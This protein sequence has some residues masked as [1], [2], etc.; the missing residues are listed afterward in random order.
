MSKQAKILL[1]VS[2]LFTMAMGLS[3]V[4]VNVLLWR[5]AKD[6]ILVAEYQLMHYIFTPL[7]FIAGGYLSKKKNGIWS[8]R[9]GISLF[10]MFFIVILFLGSSIARFVIPIGILFGIAAGFYWLAFQVLSFDFTGIDNRD[11]FNGFNGFMA[12]LAGSTAPLIAAFIIE[13][14]EGIKGYLIVFLISLILFVVMIVVSLTMRTKDDDDRL[15]FKRVFHSNNTEWHYLKLAVGSWGLRN[16]VIMFII[17]ILIYQTTGSEMSLGKLTF[18]AGLVTCFAFWLVQKIVKPK[19]RLRS[20]HV[21]AFFLFISVLGIVVEINYWYLA[22]FMV[23][24]GFFLP[25]FFVP[26]ASATFNTLNHSHEEAY[27]I[28][29]IINKE[30]SL[31]IGRIISTVILILLLT[32][33]EVHRT[34]NYFL[35]FI[36]AAQFLS[37]S[38]LR[39]IDTWDV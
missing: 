10:T 5:E 29:Y 34:L 33:F 7:A 19:H 3:N 35:L 32:F 2:A 38:F 18:F 21:G 12:S 14:N 36:G 20:M 6:F 9:V 15:D 16:V 17:T 27:R 8:L 4:F 25:F 22:F 26:V 13:K 28:E 39:R 1:V 37:L 24:N 23:V 30:I 31:N 11:T